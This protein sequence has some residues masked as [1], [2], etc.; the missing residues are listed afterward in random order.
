MHTLTHRDCSML[1]LQRPQSTLPSRGNPPSSWRERLPL[2]VP[3]PRSQPSTSVISV[4]KYLHVNLGSGEG[5]KS[6]EEP[7][8]NGDSS[9][10]LSSSPTPLP[11]HTPPSHTRPERAT[12]P[13][14]P[15]TT[16]DPLF[17]NIGK[18]E[19]LRR[20]A[21]S[22]GLLS[23]K[24]AK[25]FLE[26]GF[27]NG[28]LPHNLYQNMS[29]PTS[30]EQS[31]QQ[32]SDRRGT[33]NLSGSRRQKMERLE[34]VYGGRQQRK[35]SSRKP[36]SDNSGTMKDNLSSPG[37]T[38]CPTSRPPTRGHMRH[39]TALHKLSHRVK[40]SSR[41]PTRADRHHRTPISANRPVHR[42]WRTGG[43][44]LGAGSPLT[45]PPQLLEGVLDI[46]Q[47]C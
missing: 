7:P 32:D 21:D 42:R 36:H 13:S 34:S 19:I 38:S 4:S 12:W 31:R 40:E 37:V 29:R 2:I 5:E 24:W 43:E 3:P 39:S 20:K 25:S 16:P 6:W 30:M 9:S 27:M 22:L 44:G 28:C 15:T 8:A 46:T 23:H 35:Q 11:E 10:T 45:T 33:E 26:R 14:F 17:E 18:E 47:Q 1:F 41:P